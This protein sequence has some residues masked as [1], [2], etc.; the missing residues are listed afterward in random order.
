[1][2]WGR[3]SEGP[4]IANPNPNS[5]P[6]PWRTF[7]MPGWH[8]SDRP[9]VKCELRKCKWVFCELKCEPACDCSDIFRPTRSLPST[10][11]FAHNW[12]FLSGKNM[13]CIPAIR[14][15]SGT[16]RSPVSS[17]LGAKVPTENIRSLERKFPGTFAPGSKSSREQS[18]TGA[19]Y[20]GANCTSNYKL[21]KMHKLTL[22]PIY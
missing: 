13:T 16:F 7:A 6:I 2:V 17:L 9:R 12:N 15:G 14:I 18:F 20:W 3:H 8:P 10:T 1:M 4:P 22:K 21:H 11:T 19:I 5:N